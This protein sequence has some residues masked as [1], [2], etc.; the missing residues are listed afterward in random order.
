MKK[1]NENDPKYTVIIPTRNGS[2]YISYAIESV[3][4]S[5]RR[6]I[7]LII[8]DNHSTD[9]TAEILSSID[10]NRLKV[11][12]PQNSLPMSAHYEFALSHA[13]GAWISILGDDDALMPYTF[14]LLDKVL[15]NKS[16]VKVI[17]AKRAYYFWEG[18]PKFYGSTVISFLASNSC[19]KRWTKLDF[20]LGLLGFISCF[21]L[22]QIYTT[23]FIHR[24]LI[25]SIKAK[26]K[27]IFFHSIIPDIYSIVALMY[28]TNKYLRLEIPISWVG[29]S[30]KSMGISDRI[31]KD[32]LKLSKKTDDS[33]QKTY[34]Y[35]LANRV[36]HVLHSYG[37]TSYYLYEALKAYPLSDAIF[38]TKIIDV[39]ALSSVKLQSHN[40]SR[41]IQN[42]VTAEI[43]QA[44]RELNINPIGFRALT[45]VHQIVY[46]IYNFFRLCYRLYIKILYLFGFNY[47]LISCDRR[48]YYDILEASRAIEKLI[49][50]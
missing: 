35:K 13:K 29:T 33:Q 37:F 50:I 27:G 39:I 14:N 49:K 2:K 7:E 24:D 30:G 31:Y 40:R 36:S 15:K 3:L 6:D 34:P 25:I 9:Q 1:T 28:F 11:I 41:D 32:T 44:I 10:D 47:T 46:I 19:S 23:G 8:S 20:V 26:T 22:P 43:A 4:Q 38:Q 18:S 12:K 21:D 17:S 5:E 16:D 48:K 42:S 45:I